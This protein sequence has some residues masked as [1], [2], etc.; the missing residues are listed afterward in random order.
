MKTTNTARRL[1][2][3]LKAIIFTCLVTLSLSARA[4]YY[5][6][7]SDYGPTVMWSSC[8]HHH[9]RHRSTCSHHRHHWRA[10]HPRTSL[11]MVVYT[12]S[13]PCPCSDAWVPTQCNV[14]GGCVPA[15]WQGHDFVQFSGEPVSDNVTFVKEQEDYYDPDTATADDNSSIDP[16][17]DID[18]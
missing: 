14:C 5:V 2:L 4:E 11:T 13:P 18:N 7:Y 8:G 3:F 6:V 15:H 17:M 10:L 9:Y 16:N 1:G 12:P